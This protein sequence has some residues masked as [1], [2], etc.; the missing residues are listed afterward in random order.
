MS[1]LL[2]RLAPYLPCSSFTALNISNFETHRKKMN[3][4]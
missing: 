1:V 2:V 3:A 4:L